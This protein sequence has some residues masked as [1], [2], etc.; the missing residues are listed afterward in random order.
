MSKR[1]KKKYKMLLFL[2]IIIL[3][4]VG[5]LGVMFLNP[6]YTM[7][8]ENCELVGGSPDDVSCFIPTMDESTCTSNEYFWIE[9]VGCF[10]SYG[11]KTDYRI[12]YL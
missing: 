1:K 12:E 2:T 5:L 8:R 4:M 7:N 6:R 3:L 11:D 10:I 9:N